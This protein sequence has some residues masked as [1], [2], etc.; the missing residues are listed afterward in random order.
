MPKPL[1]HA[2]IWSHEHQHYTLMRDGQ[3]EQGFFPA[4]QSAFA[5]WLDEHTAFAFLDLDRS[6][7]DPGR[8]ALAG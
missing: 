4:D 2:L 7:K 8:L 6:A 1:Q 3:P 5:R